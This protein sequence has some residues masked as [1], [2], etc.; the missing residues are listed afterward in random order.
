MALF[1]AAWLLVSET[2][3]AFDKEK[4]IT[5]LK[6]LLSRPEDGPDRR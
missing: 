6:K 1:V 3:H 2:S 5:H 4:F